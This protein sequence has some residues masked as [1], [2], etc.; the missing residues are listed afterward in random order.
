[1]HITLIIYFINDT[2]EYYLDVN[3]IHIGIGFIFVI[4][5]N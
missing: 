3:I 4:K 2:L 5:I 1:M